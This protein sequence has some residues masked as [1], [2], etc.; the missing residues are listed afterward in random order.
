MM[1]FAPLY[2]QGSSPIN[3]FTTMKKWKNE[4]MKKWKKNDLERFPIRISQS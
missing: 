2:R 3:E 1:M 4:K